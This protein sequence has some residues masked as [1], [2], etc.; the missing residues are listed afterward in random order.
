MMDKKKEFIKVL[1]EV[2]RVVEK[3]IVVFV[4][5]KVLSRAVYSRKERVR[6]KNRKRAVTLICNRIDEI[7]K[8]TK[9]E[10]KRLRKLKDKINKDEICRDC[11]R[12]GTCWCNDC[13]DH[14]YYE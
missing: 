5:S 4:P 12:K 11:E 14:E 3:D 9:K 1:A 13:K 8:V 7:I 2:L 6:K 10:N